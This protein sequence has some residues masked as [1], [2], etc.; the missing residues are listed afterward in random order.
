M[1][2]VLRSRSSGVGRRCW[3]RACARPYGTNARSRS[4][5][6][7]SWWQS[8][9]PRRGASVTVLEVIS[10]LLQSVRRCDVYTV[11]FAV[12]VWLGRWPASTLFRGHLASGWRAGVPRLVWSTREPKALSSHLRAFKRRRIFLTTSRATAATGSG[13]KAVSS[14]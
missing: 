6:R 10:L 2:T 13:R 8:A 1:T 7:K 5:T 3:H 4:G 14:V 11:V 12:E 9:S